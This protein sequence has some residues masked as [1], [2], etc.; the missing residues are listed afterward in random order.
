MSKKSYKNIVLGNLRNRI[1]EHGGKPF[2]FKIVAC[3]YNV[4]AGVFNQ[5]DFYNN[6]RKLKSDRFKG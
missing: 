5:V 3:H 4:P 6:V 2:E 1:E